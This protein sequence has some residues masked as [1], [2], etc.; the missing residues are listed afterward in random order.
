MGRDIIFSIFYNRQ[1]DCI[2]LW[3]PISEIFCCLLVSNAA[4]ASRQE[5]VVVWLYTPG[6]MVCVCIF[7]LLTCA[8]STK[9]NVSSLFLL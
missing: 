7:L 5:V 1:V 8:L 9:S 2:V 3:I 6:H 4:P